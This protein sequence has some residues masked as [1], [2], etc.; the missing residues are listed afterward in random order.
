[1]E[2]QGD[3]MAA[4]TQTVMIVVS[5]PI[6]VIIGYVVAAVLI[7]FGRSAGR[8]PFVGSG[9]IVA[10]VV[11]VLLPLTYYGY[12]ISRLGAPYPALLS[13][14]VI[15]ASAALVSGLLIQLGIGQLRL[16]RFRTG[17]S[18]VPH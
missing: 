4:E 3:A 15:V 11:T 16:S 10:G 6:L 8:P 14:F 2:V 12:E 9:F 5:F 1:M 13:D 18:N 7:V 17:A